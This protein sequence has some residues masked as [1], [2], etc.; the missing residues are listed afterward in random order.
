MWEI[1]SRETEVKEEDISE[2]EELFK[3]AEKDK[4]QNTIVEEEHFVGSVPLSVY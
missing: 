1:E 2:K 3:K 4:D